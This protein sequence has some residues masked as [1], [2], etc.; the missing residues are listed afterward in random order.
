M[1]VELSNMII[2][3]KAGLE[4]LIKARLI[5]AKC[6]ASYN[7]GD[8]LSECILYLYDVSKPH[9][10]E[11]D[12]LKLAKK[13]IANQAYWQGSSAQPRE[14]LKNFKTKY[15]VS[16]GIEINYEGLDFMSDDDD[17]EALDFAVW[18]ESKLDRPEKTLFRLYY[19][20]G[21]SHRHIAQKIREGGIKVSDSSIYLELRKL[22]EKLKTFAQIW[23]VR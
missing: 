5:G 18:I 3:N 22:K 23:R 2:K 10:V 7:V 15:R 21:L 8:M 17:N 11:L 19:I 4:G 13:W 12:Y 9:M 16:T 20:E 6:I 1:T 14:G